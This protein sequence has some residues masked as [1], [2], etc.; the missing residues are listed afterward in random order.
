MIS[1]GF[2]RFLLQISR[3]ISRE[4][5]AARKLSEQSAALADMHYRNPN[6][7]NARPILFRLS[8][9]ILSEKREN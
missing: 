9:D 5:L 2:Q 1:T 8:V 7:N 3:Q 4:K 6:L